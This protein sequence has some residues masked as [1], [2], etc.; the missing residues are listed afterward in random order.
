MTA[1]GYSEMLIPTYQILPCRNA[2]DN[3]MNLYRKENLKVY[4]HSSFLKNCFSDVLLSGRKVS[5]VFFYLH[6]GGWN[7]GPLDTAAT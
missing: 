2:E 1:V 4:V 5:L 6:S 7:Q 3:N